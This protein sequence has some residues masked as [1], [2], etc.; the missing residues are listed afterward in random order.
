MSDA[1]TGMGARTGA[2][3]ALLG[4]GRA[5]T[6]GQ[7]VWRE[8]AADRILYLLIGLYGLVALALAA[9]AGVLGQVNL[10]TYMPVWTQA[11]ASALLL[12]IVVVEAPRSIRAAPAAP[13]THLIGR[14][15][16]LVTPRL[17][18]GVLL[19]FAVGLF[20]GVFTT[21]KTMLPQF[22]TFSWDR[23]FAE[24]DALIFGGVDPWR[25][26]H[27]VMGHVAV[28]K[29]VEFCYAGVWMLTVCA[30]PAW[31]AMSPRMAH[32]RHRFLITYFLCWILLGNV[33][34]G[35]FFSA[36]PCFYEQVTGDGA[37]Y[38]ELIAYHASTP[39]DVRSAYALQQWLWEVQ[40]EGRMHVGS[41]I[42]A[43]PSLHVA[44]ATLAAIAGFT[45]NRW[46]GALGIAWI[47]LIF[48][49]SIHLGW[50]YAV[51]GLASIVG[52]VL[53]W[54]ALRPLQRTA[55]AQP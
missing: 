48:A 9:T 31:A 42:S 49:G 40:S 20:M 38:A 3:E 7:A 22:A 50:H 43:F 39:Q 51:D 13:M 34:A 23:P 35:I 29:V 33:M 24:L 12:Y 28:S 17:V 11:I 15:A 2:L 53:I 18:S 55:P 6:F 26:L 46:M 36:G 10:L 47:A 37:R 16:E 41:G 44:M 30:A 52:V 14:T 21:V 54:L 27:P 32:Q 45:V 25:L 1:P 5:R 19:M 4:G 8:L